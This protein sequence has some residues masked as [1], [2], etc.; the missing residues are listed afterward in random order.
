[1]IN[2]ESSSAKG[3]GRFP[4]SA[5]ATESCLPFRPL[6][7]QVLFVLLQTCTDTPLITSPFS[8]LQHDQ[9]PASVL[10]PNNFK[11]PMQRAGASI[12]LSFPIILGVVVGQTV[13]DE[14]LAPLCALI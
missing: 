14:D 10:L 7:L 5:Q 1:M 11:W 9:E 12:P 2:R 3:R 8:D 13:Q 4:A 6:L